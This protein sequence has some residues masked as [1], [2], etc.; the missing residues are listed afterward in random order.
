MT[1]SGRPINT[2]L[3]YRYPVAVWRCFLYVSWSSSFELLSLC[4]ASNRIA[5][6]SLYKTGSMILSRTFSRR[7]VFS[8]N[9]LASIGFD[10]S[11]AL[12]VACLGLHAIEVQSLLR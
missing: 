11:H 12:M 8:G 7:F 2:R 1:G 6:P 9:L 5:G 4:H 10:T 3:A